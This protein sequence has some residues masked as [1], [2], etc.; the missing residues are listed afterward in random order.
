M[1]VR[2]LPLLCLLTACSGGAGAPAPGETSPA[3]AQVVFVHDNLEWKGSPPGTGRVLPLLQGNNAFVATIQLDPGATIPTHRDPTE[4]YI[5]VTAGGGMLTLDGAE[6]RLAEG[7]AVFMPANAEVSFVAGDAGV[8]GLQVF[9]G[10]ESAAK[11]DAWKPVKSEPARLGDV[12]RSSL[13]LVDAI[14]TAEAAYHAEHGAWLALP[15]CPSGDP[16]RDARAWDCGDDPAWKALGVAPES[17]G[18]HCTYEAKVRDDGFALKAFCDADGDRDR[19]ILD[20]TDERGA[21]QLTAD[22]VH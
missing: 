21:T 22:G 8:T 18:A 3:E 1:R 12:A 20:A 19:R 7:S 17:G 14:R 10:P 11:Y 5:V 9:A 2:T 6:H 4:E 16:G 15:P 13:A